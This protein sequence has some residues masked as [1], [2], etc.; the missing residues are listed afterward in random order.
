[1]E[2]NDEDASMVTYSCFAMP[3][4]TTATRGTL[5]ATQ[6]LSPRANRIC[7]MSKRT[8]SGRVLFLLTSN[9]GNASSWWQLEVSK[10]RKIKYHMLPCKERGKEDATKEDKN[11]LGGST[12]VLNQLWG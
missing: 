6:T 8:T 7:H 9:Q 10:G 4:Y 1:M 5:K 3:K 11:A 2:T 12:L